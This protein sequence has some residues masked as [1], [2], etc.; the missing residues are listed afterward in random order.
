MDE[1]VEILGCQQSSLPLK[2]LGLPLGAFHKDETIWNPILEK[3][4]QRLAGCKR[5]YSGIRRL[6]R[7]NFVSLGK[8]L[9]KYG[10]ERDALWRKVIEAKYGDEEGGWCTKPMK[11]EGGFIGT[12]SFVVHHKIGSQ[13]HLIIFGLCFIPR[14]CGVLV[15]TNFVG[16]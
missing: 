14:M 7:F 11:D 2:Y 3:M 10:T 15:M 4:E 16:S 9:W 1:L 5:L 6:R 12:F 8:W 13:N